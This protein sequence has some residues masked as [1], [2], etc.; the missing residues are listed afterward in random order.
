MTGINMAVPV[1]VPVDVCAV[2]VLRHL[3]LDAQLSLRQL[4]EL[5]GVNKGRLSIIERGATPTAAEI[6]A[7]LDA[8]Y[9]AQLGD[10]DARWTHRHDDAGSIANH[11]Q[12]GG[13]AGSFASEGCGA[14]QEIDARNGE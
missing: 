11:D 1:D 4:A 12:H 3:R 9:Q 5:T 14:C 10:H 6:H 7:M 8:I 13:A 2:G